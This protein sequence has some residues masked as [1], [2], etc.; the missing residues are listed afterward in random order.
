MTVPSR[1]S[2]P[3]ALP[4]VSGS[5]SQSSTSSA[6]WKASPSAIPNSPIRSV[7]STGSPPRRAPSVVAAEKSLPVFSRQR[8]R[9]CSGVVSAFPACSR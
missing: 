1:R 3:S 7:A 2:V 8:S 9:Y 6:I 5:P 4:V